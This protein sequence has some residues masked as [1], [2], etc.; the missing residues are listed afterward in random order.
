MVNKELSDRVAYLENKLSE[1]EVIIKQAIKLI[2]HNVS[3]LR[4]FTNP[5]SWYGE[6]ITKISN[7]NSLFLSEH[8]LY[9]NAFLDSGRK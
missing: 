4:R 5:N 6:D 3:G 2:N 8:Y 7:Q 9:Q 1:K